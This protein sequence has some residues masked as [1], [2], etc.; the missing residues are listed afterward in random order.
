MGC[1]YKY[2]NAGQG[3]IGGL[4]V[5]EEHF[6]LPPRWRASGEMPTTPSSTS[7][8]SSSWRAAP[9]RSRSGPLPVFAAAPL[10]GALDVTEAVGIGEL[11]DRSL[12]LTRYL[13]S[14]VDDAVHE[15]VRDA[16]L[17]ADQALGA[18]RVDLPLPESPQIFICCKL[19]DT[20]VD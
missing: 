14:L 5:R 2:L 4:Y 19:M 12:D 9:P 13:V 20:D 1:S 7:N 10:F 17:P 6:D 16:A 8:P 11:R 15:L 3:A 18:R